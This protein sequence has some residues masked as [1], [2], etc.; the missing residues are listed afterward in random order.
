MTYRRKSFEIVFVNTMVR[1]IL[2]LLWTI[3]KNE[4]WM[5]KTDE[6]PIAVWSFMLLQINI[7]TKA[8]SHCSYCRRSIFVINMRWHLPF[9]V[10][11]DLDLIFLRQDPH[12]WWNVSSENSRPSENEYLTCCCTNMHGDQYCWKVN[13]LLTVRYLCW[14]I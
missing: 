8:D 2:L 5:T 4:K 7:F 6:S 13:L 1:S 9:V 12:M 11:I 14:Y 10:H 3:I